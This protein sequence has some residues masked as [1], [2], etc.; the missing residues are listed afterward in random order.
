MMTP[1][2][3][4]LIYSYFALFFFIIFFLLFEGQLDM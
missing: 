2:G 3:I 1:V 4:I